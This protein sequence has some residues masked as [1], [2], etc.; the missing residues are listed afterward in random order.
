MEGHALER[1]VRDVGRVR[2]Q[3]IGEHQVRVELFVRRKRGSVCFCH[4]AQT[5][6][7]APRSRLHDT[8]HCSNCHLPLDAQGPRTVIEDEVHAGIFERL[9]VLPDGVLIVLEDEFLARL[10]GFLTDR[11]QMLDVF[12]RHV[13]EQREVLDVCNA[14]Q[15][16]GWGRRTRHTVAFPL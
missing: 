12:V 9:D 10:L 16:S 2:H 3:K 15:V 11:L 13:C 5:N 7:D 8:L 1:D 14:G 4:P 6:K